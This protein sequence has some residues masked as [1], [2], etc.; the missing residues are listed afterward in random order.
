MEFKSAGF[1][2]LRQRGKLHS[3]TKPTTKKT[4]NIRGKDIITSQNLEMV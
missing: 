1:P 2:V 4:T 3:V